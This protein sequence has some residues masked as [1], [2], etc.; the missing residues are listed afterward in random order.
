M[1]SI[2][3]YVPGRWSIDPLH[4]DVSFTV[5]HM[6]VGK[7]RGRFRR[8]S[9]EVV[10]A[11]DPLGSTV[12]ARVDMTSVDTNQEQRDAHL[13]S[14]EF[15]DVDAHPEMTYRSTGLRR[16]G[17]G[18]VLDGELTLKGVT[19]PVPLSL[20]FNGFEPNGPAGAVAGFSASGTLNRR[21]FGV[22]FHALLEGGGV[23]V[24]DEIAVTLDIEAVRQG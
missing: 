4:S 1:I 5:R 19:R 21:D 15:F 24:G 3:G 16:D 14:A 18:F 17:T 10:T 8:F 6:V 20:E 23:V 9:G 13:R 22:D 11:P 7:V 2:P 12:T